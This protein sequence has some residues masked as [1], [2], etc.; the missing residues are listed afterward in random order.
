MASLNLKQI[1]SHDVLENPNNYT[2]VNK[3]TE[4]GNYDCVILDGDELGGEITKMG[5]ICE[6]RGIGLPIFLT[7]DA[8]EKTFVIGKTGILE[9]QPEGDATVYI[10]KIVIPLRKIGE[11]D[12]TP[13]EWKLDYILAV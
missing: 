3:A 6:S 12:F 10:S 1:T 7:T 9:I 2:Y 8:V 13:L 11:P 5:Y 4:F